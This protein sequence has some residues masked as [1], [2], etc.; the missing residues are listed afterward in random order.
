MGC[1]WTIPATRGLHEN[2]GGLTK[3]L[4]GVTNRGYKGGDDNGTSYTKKRGLHRSGMSRNSCAR[5]RRGE[6]HRIS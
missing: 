5:I 6:D 4:E 3:A 1:S 2:G